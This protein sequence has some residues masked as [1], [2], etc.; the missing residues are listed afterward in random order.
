MIRPRLY[1]FRFLL[2]A[3][4]LVAGTS[5]AD[6][7]PTP[8][9]A[10][11]LSFGPGKTPSACDRG[12][13][14]V[15]TYNVAGL[16]WPLAKKG[17]GALRLIATRL[18]GMRAERCAPHVVVL[19]E[20]FSREAKA[21]GTR[22]GYPFIVEG[23]YLRTG[24]APEGVERNWMLGETAGTPIDSGLMVLS[25]LPVLDVRRAAFPEGACAGY[26]CLAAKGVVLV[27]LQLPDNRKVMVATTH[28]NSR[29]AS[30]APVART[31]DAYRREADFLAGFI[32]ANRGKDMPLIVAGDF[33][34]GQRPGRTAVL[35]T[36]MARLAGAPQDDALRT[37]MT[38]ERQPVLPAADAGTIVRRARD[39]QFAIAGERVRLTPVGADIPFGT[40]ADGS[41]LSDHIGYTIRYRY[42][43]S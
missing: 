33:N 37:Y 31:F 18:A 19:Q 41:M 20:A 35:Q 6:P 24:T 43:E 23:P 21:I 27:T 5:F 12:D 7:L 30:K 39:M 15:M 17:P 4:A 29:G 38:G 26:D 28:F 9:T 16:P 11:A 14:S 40:E 3:V 1:R 36:A 8:D 13:L 42:S 32:T 25:D 10:P 2:G 22:A 34:R